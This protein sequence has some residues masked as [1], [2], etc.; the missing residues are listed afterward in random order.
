MHLCFALLAECAA[1]GDSVATSLLDQG[2]AELV[3]CLTA[4]CKQLGFEVG[5]NDD[6]VV[7]VLSGG[8]L[9]PGGVY[10]TRLEALVRQRLPAARVVHPNMS[11]EQGA[12]QLALRQWARAEI[13]TCT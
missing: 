11:P 1:A 13:S 3:G 8:L 12:A 10:A 9:A 7:I 4:V 5:P 6:D 2:A